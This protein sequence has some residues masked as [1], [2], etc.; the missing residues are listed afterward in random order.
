MQ[1]LHT[2]CLIICQREAR[3]PQKKCY[4]YDIKLH[5]VMR[6]S[7][8]LSFISINPGSILVWLFLLGSHLWLKNIFVQIICIRQEYLK[9]YICVKTND[10]QMNYLK[11]YNYVQIICIR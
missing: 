8:E 10:Y 4:M 1:M 3:S 9:P 5:P 6:L 2:Y 7:V 11:T